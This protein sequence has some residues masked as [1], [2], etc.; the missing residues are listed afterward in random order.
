MNIFLKSFLK[1]YCIL[2]LFNVDAISAASGQSIYSL[3]S[4][5]RSNW[6]EIKNP[7]IVQNYMVGI[8]DYL[9]KG[10]IRLYDLKRKK[11]IPMPKLY[12][13][14]LNP[15]SVSVSLG[16]TKIALINSQEGNNQILV[17]YRKRGFLRRVNINSDLIP[18]KVIISA[19]GEFLAVEVQKDDL[20]QLNILQ[21]KD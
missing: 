1:I 10:R 8:I 21:L 15:I 7:T 19:S 3:D 4:Y 17:F 5:F 12:S 2:N 14:N 13:M 6:V 16:A 11:I 20:R 18:V 9:G